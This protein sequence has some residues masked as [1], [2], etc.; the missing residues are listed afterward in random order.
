MVHVV[1]VSNTT[2]LLFDDSTGMSSHLQL[3]RIQ[4]LSLLLLVK[5]SISYPEFE[6]IMGGVL[7]CVTKGRECI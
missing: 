7:L 4:T 2:V 3:S 5:P 1:V 6:I